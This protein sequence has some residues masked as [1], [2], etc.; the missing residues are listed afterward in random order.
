MPWI[1]NVSL[2]NLEKGHHIR[3]L[4]ENSVLIQ[5]CDPDHAFPTP[6]HVFTKVHQF[7]FLDAEETCGEPEELKISDAQAAEIA[8]ILKAALEKKSDVV[9]QCHAGAC[10]SGA[11]VEVGVMLGFFDTE[12]HRQPNLMVKK[13]LMIQFGMG[14]W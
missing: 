4:P 11:V 9:V 13:K 1:Q 14:Y 8:N 7:S 6:H 2:S 12:V 10:R 3:V 5:I